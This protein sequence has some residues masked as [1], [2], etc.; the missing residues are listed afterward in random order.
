MPNKYG[1]STFRTLRLSNQPP[2]LKDEEP[3]VRYKARHVIEE[4]MA[5]YEP[6]SGGNL[7]DTQPLKSWKRYRNTQYRRKP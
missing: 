1:K 4:T 2:E 6:L 5:W 3:K 7:W